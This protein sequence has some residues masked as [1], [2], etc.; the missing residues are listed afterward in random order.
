LVFTRTWN[1]WALILLI[2]GVISSLSL[3]LRGRRMPTALFFMAL[4][5]AFWFNRRRLVPRWA[6]ALGIAVFGV[7]V[8]SIGEYRLIVRDPEA[9]RVRQVTNIDFASKFK[10]ESIQNE[11][12]GEVRNASYLMEAVSRTGRYDWGLSLYNFLIK[13]YVPRQ[14][15]GADF[16]S[17]LLA[18]DSTGLAG[19][20]LGYT[21]PVG[22][23][24]T[25]VAEAFA[26]FSYFGCLLFFLLGFM[27]RR[28]WEGA[29][30][31]YLIYQF[32][33]VSL[34]V[35]E[36][37]TFSGSLSCLTNPWPHMLLFVGP[38]FWIARAG[39]P[40][41]TQAAPLNP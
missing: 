11:A 5:L 4:L 2:P 1:K 3:M 31:G 30:R 29:L 21:A 12:A 17:S 15:V 34:I 38:V 26:A 27:M 20:V 39:N 23:C 28:F 35:F 6:F 32:L 40:L 33:Y 13:G 10:P 16:K 9:D 19:A 7:F 22:S 18:D 37:G 14:I 41:W 25:G 8:Y 36:L 24:A